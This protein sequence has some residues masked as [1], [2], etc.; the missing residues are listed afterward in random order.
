[1]GVK[2]RKLGNI[3]NQ[4]VEWQSSIFVGDGSTGLTAEAGKGYF[5]DT[6]G[7]TVV[8]TLPS[9]TD[10]AVN[11][12]DQ[13]AFKD[14]NRTFGT[15]AF[16]IASNKFDGV[17][18]QTPSFSTDGQSIHLI[19]SGNTNGWQLIGEDTVSGLGAEYIAAT[20]GTVTTVNTNFK[21]HTFT[22]DGCFVV[23]SAGNSAGSNTVDYLVIAGGGGGGWDAAGGGGAGG[24]RFSDGTASGCFSAGPSPLGASALPVSA[25]TFPITVGAGGAKITSAGAGNSGS[26]SIFS[27]ITSTGGGRGGRPTSGSEAA[28]GG[29]GG[30]AKGGG[31]A[32][33]GNTPP[34]SPPQGNDG[35]TGPGSGGGGGGAGTAGSAGQP[36]PGVGGNGGAGLTSCITGSPVARGGGGAGGNDYPGSAATGGPGGGGDGGTRPSTAGAGDGTANTGGGGGGAGVPATSGGSGAGGKGIVIIRYKFQG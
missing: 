6:N 24:Y 26:N 5:I 19:Y 14:F 7:G 2:T 10:G 31:T 20:G 35:A 28:D 33:S 3:D 15:N 4:L 34:V 27:T 32:G 17:T 13:V 18:G 30:G 16:S 22:G 12:G 29:S 8:A 25:T 36:A 23:S 9:D 1:M 21:V 11:I